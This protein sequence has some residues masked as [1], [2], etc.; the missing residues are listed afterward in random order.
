MLWSL[1]RDTS[2]RINGQENGRYT[3]QFIQY[4]TLDWLPDFVASNQFDYILNLEWE[5]SS[6]SHL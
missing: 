4:V 2:W 6:Y 5:T 1:K 3:K